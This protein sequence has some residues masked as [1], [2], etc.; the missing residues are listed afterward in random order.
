MGAYI[1]SKHG[2]RHWTDSTICFVNINRDTLH[3]KFKFTGNLLFFIWEFL[4]SD[5]HKIIHKSIIMACKETVVIWIPRTELHNYSKACFPFH[6]LLFMDKN[7]WWMGP[8]N[9]MYQ[10]DTTHIDDIIN[11]SWYNHCIWNINQI[12]ID[13]SVQDCGNSIALATELI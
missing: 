13:G 7:L 3:Q 8:M 12:H 5:H 2:N 9:L 10:V 6:L 1:A 11:T 4:N